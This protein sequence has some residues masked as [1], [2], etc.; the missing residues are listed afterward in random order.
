MY[1]NWIK[2]SREGDWLLDHA[3][4]LDPTQLKGANG[5]GG[6]IKCARQINWRGLTTLF[7]VFRYTNKS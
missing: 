3:R 5:E 2:Y 4:I 7:F 1:E 6:R